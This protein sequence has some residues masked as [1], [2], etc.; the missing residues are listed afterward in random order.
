[1]IWY[2]HD[3]F[4]GHWQQRW[5]D[6][7]S[8]YSLTT[9]NRNPTY[10]PSSLFNYFFDFHWFSI[11]LFFDKFSDIFMISHIFLKNF[12]CFHIFQNFTIFDDTFR[13]HLYVYIF[14]EYYWQQRLFYIFSDNIIYIFS[15]NDN[16]WQYWQLLKRMLLYCMFI[17]SLIMIITTKLRNNLCII[18]WVN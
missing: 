1:M 14:T 10:L 18:V 4:S 7:F 13:L 2:I 8:K 3:I 11:F 9:T 16:F 15:D 5:F 12:T 6:I 17:Y